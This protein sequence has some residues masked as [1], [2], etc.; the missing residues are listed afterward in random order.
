MASAVALS[1]PSFRPSTSFGAGISL[2]MSEGIVLSGSWM[3]MPWTV[4]VFAAELS[5]FSAFSGESLSI[6]TETPMSAP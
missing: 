6:S 4:G 2:R 5:L 1:K 3:M